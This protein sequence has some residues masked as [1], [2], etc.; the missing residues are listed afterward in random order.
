MSAYTRRLLVI[1]YSQVYGMIHTYL[2]VDEVEAACK[3]L[4]LDADTESDG[5][6]FNI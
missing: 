1:V 6:C 3:E 2:T 4:Q 5:E